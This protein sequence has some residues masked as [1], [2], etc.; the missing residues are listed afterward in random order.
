M[1]L[2]INDITHRHEIANISYQ[3]SAGAINQN[4]TL[5]ILLVN[6]RSLDLKRDRGQF[7][8]E[9]ARHN[10]RICT[11]L[12]IPIIVRSRKNAEQKTK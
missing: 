4:L 3:H 10:K 11:D 1:V 8:I 12:K 7:L 2:L 5:F 6:S 9:V